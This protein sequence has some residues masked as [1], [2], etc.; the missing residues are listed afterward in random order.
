MCK[1]NSTLG[2][3]LDCPTIAEKQKVDAMLALAAKAK[4][5]K[6]TSDFLGTV[7]SSNRLFALPAMIDAFFALIAKKNGIVPVSVISAIELDKK[8]TDEITDTLKKALGS[9]IALSLK[10]DASLLGGLMIKI[11]SVLIDSSLRSK[12][13]QL[14]TVM[15]GA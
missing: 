8:Q 6:T 5:S 13:Q 2:F 11:G 1:E 15:K 10:V 3:M 7:A 12:V 14:K 9:S 4:F